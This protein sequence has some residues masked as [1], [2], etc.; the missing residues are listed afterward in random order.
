M[1]NGTPDRKRIDLMALPPAVRWMLVLATIVV[2]VGLVLL[3]GTDSGGATVPVSAIGAAVL[4]F[5]FVAWRSQR[6]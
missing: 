6:R 5:G 2:V 4:A 3:F 1:P